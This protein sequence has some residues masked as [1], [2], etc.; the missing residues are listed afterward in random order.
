MAKKKA[1]RERIVGSVKEV[2][3]VRQPHGAK[4]IGEPVALKVRTR[5][6]GRVQA[7][8]FAVGKKL[9][10]RVRDLA[11]VPEQLVGHTFE[12]SLNEAGEIVEL[13]RISM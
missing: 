11:S 12:F 7:E 4:R 6:E 10:S 8:W 3:V 1:T 5:A 9:K 2:D 13:S